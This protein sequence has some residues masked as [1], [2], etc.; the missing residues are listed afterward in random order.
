MHKRFFILEACGNSD[1][2]HECN[3]I[4]EHAKL[5]NFANKKLVG[6]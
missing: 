6:Q 5:Y 4:Y 2:P 1:E 3:G